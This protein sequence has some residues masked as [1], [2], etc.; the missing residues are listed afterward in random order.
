MNIE[1]YKE[2]KKALYDDYQRK[3]TQ[4]SFEYM[5][6]NKKYQI[7]DI[8]ESHAGIIKVE[9]ITF[10]LEHDGTPNAVYKGQSLT[11]KFEPKKKEGII[12]IY[13]GNSGIIKHN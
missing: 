12:S 2:Q 10:Y 4:L 7:G 5:M 11:K 6:A 1:Q 8:I 9:K 13:G 3:L